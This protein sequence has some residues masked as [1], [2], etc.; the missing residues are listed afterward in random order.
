MKSKYN[1]AFRAPNAY[2]DQE[3]QKGRDMNFNLNIKKLLIVTA[4]IT[5]V[6]IVGLSLLIANC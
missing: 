2:E 4:A 1:N 5:T 6:I 3:I